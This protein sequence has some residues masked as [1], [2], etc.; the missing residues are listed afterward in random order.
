M[1]FSWLVNGGDPNHVSKSW[2][3]P[4]SNWGMVQYVTAWRII[5][6]LVSS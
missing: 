6:G 4:P 1:A 5:S 3:D 2:D